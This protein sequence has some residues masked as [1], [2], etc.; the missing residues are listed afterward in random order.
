MH[1]CQRTAVVVSCA[2]AAREQRC[3]GAAW[4]GLLLL[5]SCIVLIVTSSEPQ[6]TTAASSRRRKDSSGTRNSCCY[7]AKWHS[8]T[9]VLRQEDASSHA[10]CVNPCALTA[11]VRMWCASRRTSSSVRDA[12]ATTRR[13]RIVAEFRTV[14]A[15]A[16]TCASVQS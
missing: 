15:R 4:S 14:F 7:T 2:R 10:T 12:L 9:K 11:P 16:S 6:L 3:G 8:R 5:A 1:A 13:R